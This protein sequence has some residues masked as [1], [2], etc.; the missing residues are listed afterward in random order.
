MGRIRKEGLDGIDVAQGR[1]K[2]CS[3]VSKL[4]EPS[5]C[6]KF[7]YFLDR[8]NIIC[9]LKKDINPLLLVKYDLFG[10]FSLRSVRTRY[11]NM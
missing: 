2:W 3:L 1:D 5:S 4:N 10:S 11:R 8:L 7:G 6:T 9:L